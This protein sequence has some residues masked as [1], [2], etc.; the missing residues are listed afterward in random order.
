MAKNFNN[1][2]SSGSNTYIDQF[3]NEYQPKTAWDNDNE[4]FIYTKKES[5][6]ENTQNQP[7]PNLLPAV[8]EEI[9]KPEPVPVKI[10]EIAI[11]SADRTQTLQEQI[12]HKAGEM[13]D[14]D[15]KYTDEDYKDEERTKL[16]FTS[17]VKHAFKKMWEG[18]A[19]RGFYEQ[20]YRSEM[21]DQL[22][23]MNETLKVNGVDNI[24]D[25]SGERLNQLMRENPK[26]AM[27]TRMMA[28]GDQVHTAAGEKRELITGKESD[29][30]KDMINKFI[31]GQMD[32]DT[33]EQ[34]AQIINNNLHG[35][36][37]ATLDNILAAAEVAKSAVE[38]GAAMQDVLDHIKL[39]KAESR[40]GVRTQEYRDLND[41]IV[42]KLHNRTGIP[43]EYIAGA[44]GLAGWVAG[45][46]A[47]SKLVSYFSLGGGAALS[48][49]MAARTESIR[50]QKDRA[51]LIR[52]KAMNNG[53]VV[54]NDK[55]AEQIKDTAFDMISADKLSEAMNTALASGDEKQIKDALTQF[56]T[57][58]YISDKYN[59][60][61]ISYSSEKEVEAE[62]F[63]L[64]NDELRL[65]ATL[66]AMH[67]DDRD[68]LKKFS[69]DIT[70]PLDR[71]YDLSDDE[72]DTL[73]QSSREI[74]DEVL[75]KDEAADK[76][77][78]RRMAKQGVKTA[79]ITLG[80][81]LA[82][83]EIGALF[84]SNTQGAIEGA[85]GKNNNAAHRTLLE[86]GRVGLFGGRSQYN[87]GQ[88]IPGQSNYYKK[89][90]L[91]KAQMK[92]LRQEGYTITEDRKN[93]TVKGNSTGNIGNNGSGKAFKRRFWYSNNSNTPNGNELRSGTNGDS[94]YRFNPSGTSTGNGLRLTREDM[95][96][97]ANGGRIQL[98]LSPNAQSAGHPLS[99]NGVWRN[100]GVEFDVGNNSEAARMLKDGSFRFAEV[101]N[102]DNG[103]IISTDI[104][105]GTAKSVGN[106]VGRAAKNA[107]KS[108][109]AGY[110]V[111]A[112]D[113]TKIV[114]ITTNVPVPIALGAPRQNLD[115]DT[116]INSPFDS[117]PITIE[118][119]TGPEPTPQAPTNLERALDDGNETDEA[120]PTAAE[121]ISPEAEQISDQLNDS[122]NQIN[123]QS[124]NNDNI[125]RRI[126]D[127][128]LGEY[129]Y[130]TNDGNLELNEEAKR[131][132]NR[133]TDLLSR[134]MNSVDADQPAED[135]ARVFARMLSVARQASTS[136][137]EKPGKVSDEEMTNFTNEIASLDDD[138]LEQQQI[139]QE[140]QNASSP[141]DIRCVD[142]LEANDFAEENADGTV[143][144]TS[145]GQLALRKASAY[146]PD[147]SLDNLRQALL[148]N[149]YFSG[150]EKQ[151]TDRYRYNITNYQMNGQANDMPDYLKKITDESTDYTTEDADDGGTT[152]FQRSTS[153]TLNSL[154]KRLLTDYLRERSRTDNRIYS[155]SNP[156]LDADSLDGFWQYCRD[157]IG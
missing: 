108:V 77:R 82:A 65:K 54:A 102:A 122:L 117:G 157:N 15:L 36:D 154:G 98:K 138:Q 52:Q 43:R 93:I 66:A 150:V 110:N 22:S 40:E 95:R 88:I 80:A 107:V 29:D 20:R 87:T 79:A 39:Y 63:R 31:T 86:R 146:M 4:D 139:N 100:G 90:E 126:E 92:Q 5:E 26:F 75:D 7:D 49:V 115:I 21:E 46:A 23:D 119:F 19:A 105:S 124:N 133:H 143:E 152:S 153:Y 9:H 70:D 62:R 155:A 131:I 14:R 116:Q 57:R 48:G 6:P 145:K 96:Q 59:V 8:V 45:K 81:G 148:N 64:G 85:L 42:D 113:T 11:I 125:D 30:V 12:R 35:E 69:S 1:S 17:R 24:G 129:V 120:T 147:V 74:I 97:L 103:G 32:A 60:D 73:P 41:K 16:K 47:R 114:D 89:G 27:I 109:V 44:A 50:F 28:G 84:S 141:D 136:Y 137:H 111:T 51:N 118:G 112:P 101:V 78:H 53:E 58:K 128:G 156:E 134:Y 130:V 33:L 10:G 71:M 13:I 34:N 83:Q 132:I 99:F 106:T 144:L 149:G 25:L 18:G 121:I 61:L 76:L 3:G 72:Y 127:L 135:K 151:I 37:A 38:H 56:I 104:G 142:W 140:L 91:T 94:V 2:H 55:S 68:F 123:V 67:Q